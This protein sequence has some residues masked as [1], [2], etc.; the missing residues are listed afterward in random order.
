VDGEPEDESSNYPRIRWTAETQYIDDEEKIVPSEAINMDGYVSIF[1]G[2]A[3]PHF[4]IILDG[5][6]CQSI[7]EIDNLQLKFFKPFKG[8]IAT[9]EIQ[10]DDDDLKIILGETGVPFLDI[11]ELEIGRDDIL[12]ICLKPALQAYYSYYPVIRNEE[13]VGN[14]SGNTQF[15]I[16]MPPFAFNANCFFT[17]GAGTAGVGSALSPFS[18]VVSELVGGGQPT[19]GGTFGRGLT[20]TKPVP[21]FSG[22]NFGGRNALMDAMAER[23]ALLNKFRREK[24][25][26]IKENGKIYITGYSVLGGALNVQWLMWNPDWDMV[27]F[28]HLKEVRDLCT[29]YV[30]RNLGSLRHLIKSDTPG[31]LDFSQ[32]LTRADALEQPILKRWASS[33]ETLRFTPSRGGL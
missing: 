27:E 3:L 7:G 1:S 18:Y 16:Q 6:T 32:Y 4:R 33:S 10:I 9:S 26:R 24:V 29:A 20:Y 12:N 30:L 8:N 5:E 21:G 2:V 17:L 23:Q 19:G 28:E 13:N 11:G 25:Q 31:A 15:K 14:Y 22:K